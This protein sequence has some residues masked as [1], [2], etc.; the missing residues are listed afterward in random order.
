MS[1]VQFKNI[2]H[3]AIQKE[4]FYYLI[5]KKNLQSKISYIEYSSLTMQAYL[6]SNLVINS[7][8]K[9]HFKARSSM[10][11]LRGN[12]K[13]QFKESNYCQSC[14]GKSKPETQIHLYNCEALSSSEISEVTVPYDALFGDNLEK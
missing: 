2:I 10:L 11:N 4:A 3:E 14:L 9:F 12:F 1:K 8:A 13:S 5:Q 7:E 6:K